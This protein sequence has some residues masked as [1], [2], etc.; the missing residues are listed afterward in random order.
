MIFFVSI[1]IIKKN[2]IWI[3]SEVDILNLHQCEYC[4]LRGLR[5][6]GQEYT[7]MGFEFRFIW[8]PR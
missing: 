4:I 7:E 2:F 5:S 1:T 3:I 6:H 8:E